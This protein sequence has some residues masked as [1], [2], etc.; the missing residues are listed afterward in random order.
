MPWGALWFRRGVPFS[1]KQAVGLPRKSASPAT[2]VQLRERRS[3]FAKV[4]TLSWWST[5]GN[6]EHL[7]LATKMHFRF[8]VTGFNLVSRLAY[9]FGRSAQLA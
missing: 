7:C 2:S 9:A 8:P 5:F 6:L 3:K 1:V 4:P